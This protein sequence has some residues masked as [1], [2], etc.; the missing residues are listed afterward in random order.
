MTGVPPVPDDAAL[1][2]TALEAT[3]KYLDRRLPQLDHHPNLERYAEPGEGQRAGYGDPALVAAIVPIFK[4][5][6]AGT[7]RLR[8]IISRRIAENR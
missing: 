4:A 2:I 8:E 6:D 7:V 3:R 1:I 5:I